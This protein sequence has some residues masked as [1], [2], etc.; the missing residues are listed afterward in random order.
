MNIRIGPN[1]VTASDPR[2]APCNVADTSRLSKKTQR[3]FNGRDGA[4]RCFVDARVLFRYG[5][6][7]AADLMGIQ[8]EKSWMS[9]TRP[10][11]GC[12]LKTTEALSEA[13]NAPVSSHEQLA[14]ADHSL[15]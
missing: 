4:Q 11:R 1:T 8:W 7:H 2:S 13:T 3:N 15:V 9:T 10:S 12:E 6:P 5:G 14:A